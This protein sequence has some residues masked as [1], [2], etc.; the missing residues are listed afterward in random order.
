M[1][2][3]VNLLII[4]ILW[5]IVIYYFLG[6][7]IDDDSDSDYHISPKKALRFSAKKTRAPKKN[8]RKAS[9]SSSS[10]SVRPEADTKIDYDVLSLDLD[11]DGRNLTLLP[12]NSAITT[13]PITDDVFMDTSILL[14]N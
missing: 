10:R 8:Q 13:L 14:Y 4:F 1:K 6:I 7:S 12:Y 11:S 2:V 9:V 5:L 3:N